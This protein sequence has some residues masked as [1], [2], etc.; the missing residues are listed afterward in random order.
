MKRRILFILHPSAFILGCKRQHHCG[1]RVAVGANRG[2]LGLAAVGADLGGVA[3]EHAERAVPFYVVRRRRQRRIRQFRPRVEQSMDLLPPLWR[4]QQPRVQIKMRG[5]VEG[6]SL[7]I[8]RGG[9]V[10]RQRRPNRRRNG[11][12]RRVVGWIE[13]LEDGAPDRPPVLRRRVTRRH[14]V[15]QL[16]RG[17]QDATLVHLEEQGS[18]V[19]AQSV[20]R[21]VEPRDAGD[22][23]KRR[24]RRR[25][26]ARRWVQRDPVAIL[27]R[28]DA[29]LRQ[30]RA[31]R[32]RRDHPALPR[33]RARFAELQPRR[34]GRVFDV[35]AKVLRRRAIEHRRR[36]VRSV[37]RVPV[38]E[39][40]DG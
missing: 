1:L 12:F 21:P 17:E 24:R 22:L 3:F 31:E 19:L 32:V 9:L 37:P 10:L 15:A 30:R 7:Q 39:D 40:E 20:H 16:R 35:E 34:A 28:D 38:G 23:Q 8:R 14:E 25:G 2:A 5:A 11:Q 4:N 6:G 27:H 33:R 26:R 29:H 36:H 18:V 13:F